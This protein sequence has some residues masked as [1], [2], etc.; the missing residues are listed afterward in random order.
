ME[1]FTEKILNWNIIYKWLYSASNPFHAENNWSLIILQRTNPN[2]YL[3]IIHVKVLWKLFRAAE[4][5]A[6]LK[7]WWDQGK[8][9]KKENGLCFNIYLTQPL[10][11]SIGIQ[12]WSLSNVASLSCWSYPQSLLWWAGLRSYTSQAAKSMSQT[13]QASG[14]PPPALRYVAR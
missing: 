10:L 4:N 14:I 9:K 8:R 6:A 13:R 12:W 1:V 3:L 2:S 7:T 5:N 11:N